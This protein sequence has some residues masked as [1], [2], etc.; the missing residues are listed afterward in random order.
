METV[1]GLPPPAPA[2]THTWAQ[3]VVQGILPNFKGS[4]NSFPG[5]IVSEKR[6]QKNH[7]QGGPACVMRPESTLTLKP[8]KCTKRESVHLL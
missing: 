7:K 4:V 2:K 6:R 1:V 8:G 5:Q 3:V